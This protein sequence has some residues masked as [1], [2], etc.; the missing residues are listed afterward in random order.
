[1]SAYR[2]HQG[3]EAHG[4][5]AYFDTCAAQFKSFCVAAAQPSTAIRA[6]KRIGSLNCAAANRKRRGTDFTAQGYVAL[7]WP[8]IKTQCNTRK[9]R[10]CTAWKFL[11]CGA[12]ADTNTLKRAGTKRCCA[13]EQ[14]HVVIRRR[15]KQLLKAKSEARS[16]SHGMSTEV[17]GLRVCS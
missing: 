16:L 5:E 1:M 11:S 6:M 12:C 15:V 17:F 13:R 2:F 7:Q 3:R 9:L 4:V 14:D 8:V 10:L